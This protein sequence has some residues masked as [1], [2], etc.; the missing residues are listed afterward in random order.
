[1]GCDMSVE[2]PPHALMHTFLR[3]KGLLFLVFNL[4][5]LYL[6]CVL[7]NSQRQCLPSELWAIPIAMR[8]PPS[9]R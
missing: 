5:V 2:I 9:G 8:F 7:T 3:Y 1:M 6:G 4:D